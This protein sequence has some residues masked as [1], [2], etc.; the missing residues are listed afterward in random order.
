MKTRLNL[1]IDH[2]LVEE[3][4]TFASK[5]QTSISEMVEQFFRSAVK[6]GKRKNIVEIVE[7]L[8]KPA[9][10]PTID[11]KELYYKE[12]SKKYGFENIS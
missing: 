11:L 9:I 8:E 6:S 1:S 2:A 5:K 4:K 10:D 3:M 12:Q 7:K